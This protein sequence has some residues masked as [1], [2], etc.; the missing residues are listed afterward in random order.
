M[1]KNGRT[2]PPNTPNIA[3]D[4]PI[5]LPSH[6]SLEDTGETRGH[7][8]KAIEIILKIKDTVKD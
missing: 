1:E 4:V 6:I 5:I 3:P 8:E 2:P 7:F